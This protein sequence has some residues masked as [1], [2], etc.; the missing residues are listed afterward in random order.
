MSYILAAESYEVTTKSQNVTKKIKPKQTYE[1]Y[2]T[3]ESFGA[4]RSVDSILK[5]LNEHSDEPQ[6]KELLNRYHRDCPPPI[7]KNSTRRRRTLIS[8][9]GLLPGTLTKV[10]ELLAKTLDARPYRM[11]PDCLSGLKSKFRGGANCTSEYAALCRYAAS[12]VMSHTLHKQP[13]VIYKYWHDLATFSFAR[14][15]VL[16]KLPLPPVNSSLYSLPDEL[17]KPKNVFFLKLI[18]TY[19]FYDNGTVDGGNETEATN[20][21]RRLIFFLQENILKNFYNPDVELIEYK[22]QYWATSLHKMHASIV[23]NLM[24]PD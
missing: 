24:K 21:T 15:H 8:V 9:E 17:E 13:A 22:T 11:P 14:A 3:Y 6:V 16:A 4:Y 18:K 2:K 20:N 1:N 23:K 5:V 7:P 12:N 19:D 10:P